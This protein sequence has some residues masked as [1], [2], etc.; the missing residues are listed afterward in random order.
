MKCL[1]KLYCICSFQ[2]IYFKQNPK[3]KNRQG[4]ETKTIWLP[5]DVCAEEVF[6]IDKYHED[7]KTFN[8]TD[9]N[10]NFIGRYNLYH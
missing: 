7:V 3:P 2:K 10:G 9:K 4:E 5:D 1:K 6:D 8:V